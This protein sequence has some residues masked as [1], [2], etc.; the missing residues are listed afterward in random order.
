M[1]TL[2]Q[3]TL[4]I[5]AG[6]NGAGKSTAYENSP[7][8]ASNLTIINPDVYA[9]ESAKQLGVKSINDLPRNIQNRINLK[10]GKQAVKAREYAFS[11]GIDFG[12][13]TTATSENTLKLI[14]KAHSLKYRVML[15]YF[16]LPNV[17]LHITRVNQRVKMGG[18]FVSDEDI[19]R[20]Y[21]RANSLFPKL[22]NKADIAYVY[23]NT[24]GYN[25][26][27]E[28][29]NGKYT[30]FPSNEEIKEKL[31]KAVKEI[32]KRKIKMTN[33]ER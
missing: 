7:E 8:I 14:D 2:F 16:M 25:L 15:I 33:I 26:A 20:R 28:K 23:D 12:I 17:D 29:N 22:L 5:V 1:T 4:V 9:K 32:T 30:L 19:S 13:E 6:V 21:I 27:L 31:E 24:Y 10:A 11:K 3:R 18:H